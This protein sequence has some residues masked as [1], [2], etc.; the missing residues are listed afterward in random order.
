MMMNMNEPR[1][2]GL[3]LA[4]TD[5]GTVCY[6]DAAEAAVSRLTRAVSRS[7][8]HLNGCTARIVGRSMKPSLTGYRPSGGIGTHRS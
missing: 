5:E 1:C 8:A 6:A 3:G 2:T 7:V 4:L